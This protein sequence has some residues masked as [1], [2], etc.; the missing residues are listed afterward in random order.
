MLIIGLVMTIAFVSI[1]V[2]G[3]STILGVAGSLSEISGNGESTATLE[4]DGY[5]GLYSSGLVDCTVTDPDGGDIAVGRPTVNVEVNDKPMFGAFNTT[6][7]GEYT[8]ACKS[9]SN[10]G[11]Y[12]GKGATTGG[13]VGSVA[14]IILSILGLL[15]GVPMAIGGLIWLNVR[16]SGN[17]RATAAQGAQITGSA[18]YPGAPV[19]AGPLPGAPLGQPAPYSQPGQFTQPT[20]SAPSAAPAPYAQ[21][22]PYASQEVDPFAP[23]TAVSLPNHDQGGQAR[24]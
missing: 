6:K 23:T 1:L 2:A 17:R 7:A 15:V 3:I 8:I 9:P 20:P 11:V 14:G 5:Y 24:Y 19:P 12:L 10:L 16:R 21:P 4:E 13:I 18:P 22:G